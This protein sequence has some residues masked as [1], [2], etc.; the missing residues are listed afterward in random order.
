METRRLE[1]LA[2]LSRLGSMRAVADVLGTTTSTVSQ[3]LAVLAREMGTPLLEPAGRRVRLTPAGHRLAEHATTILAAVEAAQLDLQPGAEP[4]GTLR[5]AGFATAIRGYLLPVLT[6]LAAS[7]PRVRVLV[8]EHEPA[9]ALR[10]LATDEADLALVYDYNL[11]PAPVDQATHSTPLWTARWGLGVPAGEPASGAT[12]LQ[13]FARFRGHDWIGNSRNSADE[14]VIRTLAAMAGFTPRI[15]H[16][17][18]SLDLVQDMITAGLG[19][20]LLP[21]GYPTRPKVRFLPLAAPQVELRAYAAARH[22]R[23][24]WPPLTLVSGLLQRAGSRPGQ[25]RPAGAEVSGG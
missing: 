24:N 16:Q 22:G 23:L 11:A 20:G 19:V 4:N 5:V 17:A 25:D 15:T 3:Q 14:D 6:G 12:T 1:L 9:E 8:R 18:D 21:V 2:E 7:H 13:V 10:L